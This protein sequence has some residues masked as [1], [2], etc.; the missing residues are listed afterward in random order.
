VNKLLHILLIIIIPVFQLISCQKSSDALQEDVIAKVGN[1]ELTLEMVLNEVPGYVLKQ[2][3]MSAIEQ[4]RSSWIEKRTIEREARKN[5]LHLSPAFTKRLNRIQNQLLI[6]IYK[7][8]LLNEFKDDL[9]VSRE[10]SQNYFQANKERFVLDEKY[11]RFRHLT[12]RTRVEADN[13]RREL[14]RGEDWQT[15]VDKYSI[16]PDKQFQ[17]SEKFFPISMA[18]ADIRIMNQYLKVIGRTEI[19]PIATVGGNFHF[20]QLMEEKAAGDHPNLDWLIEQI[21]DW[22][23][24]EKSR[25]LVNTHIR[26]LYLQAEANNEIE[27]SNVASIKEKLNKYLNQQNN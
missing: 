7:E 16:E 2:D 24:L 9:D 21:R 10:E 22:L 1:Y 23:F 5:K 11:V 12:T 15:V 27:K 26:N 3:T 6:D 17:N 4:Y 25:R 13:A 20:V 14:L 19:S 8:F 18:L